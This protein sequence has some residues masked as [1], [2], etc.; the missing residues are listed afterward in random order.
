MITI[1]DDKLMSR[2]EILKNIKE[3]LYHNWLSIDDI[4]TELVAFAL[5]ENVELIKKELSDMLKEEF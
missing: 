4:N 1:G 3:Y 2:K 5:N